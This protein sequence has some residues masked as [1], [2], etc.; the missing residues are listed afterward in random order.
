M[1]DISRVLC[2]QHAE[3]ARRKYYV[4]CFGSRPRNQA[5]PSTKTHAHLK[6]G[7]TP[8]CGVGRMTY[9][10]NC[11]PGMIRCCFT[12][13]HLNSGR[14]SNQKTSHAPDA[15]SQYAKWAKTQAGRIKLLSKKLT[16]MR[17]G[18]PVRDGCALRKSVSLSATSSCLFPAL[19]PGGAVPPTITC[20]LTSI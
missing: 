7:G 14:K 10:K 1:R 2:R 20:P 8:D 16:T 5:S 13:C 3:A 11:I 12:K 17:S 15:F 6:G 9:S 19:A 18:L 4:R